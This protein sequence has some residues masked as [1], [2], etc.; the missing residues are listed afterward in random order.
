MPIRAGTMRNR[1][2]VHTRGADARDAGGGFTPSSTTAERWAEIIDLTGREL[3]RARQV[4]AEATHRIR[5]R[6]LEGL[7]AQDWIEHDGETYEVG[8]VANPD[9]RNREMVITA[10]RRERSA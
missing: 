9:R 2:T 4:V 10:V 7:Q 8:H 6:Y 1:V 5:I 3:E